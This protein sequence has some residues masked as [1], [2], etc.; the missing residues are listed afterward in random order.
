MLSDELNSS[1]HN[2]ILP[3][4]T[5]SE[6][7]RQK[8][9]ITPLLFDGSM[10]AQLQ[11]RGMKPGELPESYNLTNP[12]WVIDIQKNYLAAGATCL[13]TNTLGTNRFLYD[14]ERFTLAE[15]IAAGIANGRA[16]IAIEKE[17]CASIDLE[18][19][20][21]LFFDI[22][23]IGQLLAP[24][25]NLP[26]EDA[27]DAF[28]EQVL[29]V[30]DSV[31]AFLIETISDLYEMKA[32]VL[33]VKENSSLPVF[34]TMTFTA[35]QKSLTG[36]TPAA[37]VA[38]LE[39]MGVDALGVNCSLGPKEVAPIVEQILSVARIPVLVQ[40]NAGLPVYSG[41]KTT[42]NVTA[43][44][45]ASYL[46]DFV[47]AGAS[48]VGGCCGTTPEY[49]RQ[50]AVLLEGEKV[51]RRMN[52]T[53]TC[54]T[55]GSDCVTIG[56]RVIV[57]GERLNPTGKKKLKDALINQRFDEVILEAMYQEQAGADV[58]DVNVGIPG[59]DEAATMVKVIQGVQEVIRLPLQIDSASPEVL[60]KACR[61][62][63]G[64][65]LINSVNGKKEV[66]DAVFPIVKKYGGVVLGLTIDHD[67]IPGMA[68]DRLAI[69]R[70]IV[71]TAESYGIDRSDV[72][73]DCLVLTASAQQKEVTQTLKALTLVK[74][75][76]GVHTVLGCSN[77]SFGLPNRPLINKTFLAMAL[78]AGLDLPIINPLDK[79][80]MST[81]DAFEV[82]SYKD[83]DSSRYISR[84]AGDTAAHLLPVAVGSEATH[85]SGTSHTG[86]AHEEM[87]IKEMVISGMKTQIEAKTIS[88]R[89]G[90][91]ALDIINGQLIPG[92][93]EVGAK[94]EAG[95]L[96]LPQL[97]LSAET[98]KMAFA[99]LKD[100]FAAGE[101][102]QGKGPILLATVEGDV[103]DIGKNIVRIVMESYGYE[104]ID[105]GKDV[106][107]EKIAEAYLAYKPK[108][109]GLSALMT[110]TVFFMEK[111]IARLKQFPGIC[112]IIVGGAV[113]TP[114]VA[115]EIGADYYAKDAMESVAIA[116][117]IMKSNN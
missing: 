13:I 116:D 57:C 61:I 40:P 25:G 70:R 73:I 19:E 24:M 36:T 51:H 21:F 18:K 87:T 29:I 45:F 5:P 76:L 103:H 22:G 79:D 69:A 60:E 110:T 112:P 101:S 83:P 111:T 86:I 114:D 48:A 74:S 58:L 46:Y 95:Q 99:V 30:K 82:L 49:I 102:G 104:V 92:L 97:I 91:S 42:Y 78:Y 93:N 75:E 64:K 67:G 26:F 33:A 14:D 3:S 98:A 107:A 44:E 20:C 66:M 16:A 53:R 23:S 37:M 8:L 96:F 12:D 54:I 59:I 39:G 115:K 9:G 62:Y 1:S 63:N 52:P 15:V 47:R 2:T 56:D 50:A 41:N 85:A 100:S 80:L 55:S 109:I 113:I 7:L 105:L 68:E 28:K 108:M 6:R 71:E 43:E 84:H 106:P 90:S 10:G 27:Y 77:V 117:Q 4:S 32:A 17:R 35:N 65:P 81:I 31:D 34:A 72:I 89:N 11:A 38:L 94:Y 88:E